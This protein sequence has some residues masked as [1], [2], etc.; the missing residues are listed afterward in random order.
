MR[1]SAVLLA[2]FLLSAPAWAAG[3]VPDYAI[4]PMTKADVD[5]YLDIMRAAA[6]HNQHL[7]GDDKAAVDL[8]IQMQKHPPDMSHMTAGQMA[9]NANLMARAADLASYDEKVAEQRGV[10]ARYDA[11][12]NEV[13]AVY[14]Q[15]TGEGGSCAGDDCGGQLTAA[16]I[17][18]G[19]QEDATVRA[20]KPLIAPHVAEIKALKKQIG[21]F[22]FGGQ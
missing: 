8:T 18:R 16:Q 12:K 14:A 7:A 13:E 20:D 19:K 1:P 11:I 2:G 3:P 4:T 6:A 22:M 15:V 17:A 9:R 21:G 5:F 10:T